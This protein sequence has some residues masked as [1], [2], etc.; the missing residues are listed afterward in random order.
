MK[1]LAR[2]LIFF[3]I[4]IFPQI[5]TWV[6]G[7]SSKL[8]LMV[9]NPQKRQLRKKSSWLI[10]L[11]LKQIFIVVQMFSKSKKKKTCKIPNG[12]LSVFKLSAVEFHSVV[13]ILKV[14]ENLAMTSSLFLHLIQKEAK[15][16][17][18]FLLYFNLSTSLQ[19]L[20]WQSSV[21]KQHNLIFSKYLL[22]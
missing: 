17:I 11:N 20:H 16:C 15:C 9:P 18:Q 6:A 4:S 19:K 3:M 22:S 1:K 10:Y 12:M 5:L 14:E 8:S 2:K 7:A 21:V 13:K